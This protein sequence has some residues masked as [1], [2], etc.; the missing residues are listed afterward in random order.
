MSGGYRS[1]AA[2]GN[3][4]TNQ[5]HKLLMHIRERLTFA[6]VF[7]VC[8][9]YSIHKRHSLFPLF[10]FFFQ[11]S[12]NKLGVLISNAPGKTVY[13]LSEENMKTKTSANR[14]YWGVRK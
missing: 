4:T 2:T 9:S 7:L 5:G 6:F 10:F 11:I 8:Q 14:V 1:I 3:K 12:H 13:S